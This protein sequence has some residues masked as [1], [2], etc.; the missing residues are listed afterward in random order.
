MEGEVDDQLLPVSR[1]IPSPLFLRDDAPAD[2]PIDLDHGRTD[3]PIRPGAS[4]LQQFGH[5]IEEPGFAQS[6]RLCHF[7]APF[8]SGSVMVTEVREPKRMMSFTRFP[9][10][11]RTFVEYSRDTESVIIAHLPPG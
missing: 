1:A 5:L 7:A 3:R 2:L 10:A 8:F 9:S 4:L 11:D 6:G